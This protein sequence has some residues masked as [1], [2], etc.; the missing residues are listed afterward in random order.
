VG[1]QS[2][3]REMMDAVRGDFERLRQRRERGRER[4]E[5]RP[6]QAEKVVATPSEPPAAEPHE[7]PL[8]AEVAPEPDVPRSWRWVRR[9]RG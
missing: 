5:P 1:E 2:H 9:R 7:P 4:G 6:V 3:K 8:A